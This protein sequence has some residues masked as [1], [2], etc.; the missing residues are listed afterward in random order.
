MLPAGAGPSSRSARGEGHYFRHADQQVP[1]RVRGPPTGQPAEKGR[2]Q[3]A[4][5]SPAERVMAES[6]RHHRC[7]RQASRLAWLAC[8]PRRKKVKQVHR[9]PHEQDV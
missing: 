8:T 4:V 7:S 9:R 5:S 2:S 3:E 6:L 1:W